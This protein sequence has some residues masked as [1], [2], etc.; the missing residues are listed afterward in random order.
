Q[1]LNKRIFGALI[2]DI[3]PAELP[4]EL[5]STWQLVELAGGTDHEILRAVH[6]FTGEERHASF[7][8]GGLTRLRA[9]LLKAGLD[10][11][12]FEW[13][14]A[15]D[16]DRPPYRGMKP[17]EAEDAGIFFGREAPTID[18]L[19]Q[20]R[21]LR[22]G[23]PPKLLVILGASG[24]GKSSFMRAGVLPRLARDDRNFL[25]LPVLRPGS[26]ALWGDAGLM[27]VLADAFSKAGMKVTQ[28]A[29]RE[30]LAKALKDP[31]SVDVLG[32]WFD[33][34][35]ALG[36]SAALPGEAPVTPSLVLPID[37]GEEL[38]ASEGRD[39]A[40]ACLK[41][42]RLFAERS[43]SPL[44]V[45]FT[46]RSDSY[47]YLQTSRALEGLPQH[48]F[49]LM[50]MPAGAYHSIIEGPAA[51]LASS[52]RP[53]SIDPALTETL[54]RDIDQGG[55]KDA[56]PLLAFTLE[57]L[58]L[59]YGGDGDLTL[60]EYKA[61]GGVEG[62]ISAA[63]EVVFEMARSDPKLPDD[64]GA[65]ELLVRRALVP[66]LA[67][68]DPDTHAPRRRVARLR[69]IPAEAQPVIRHLVQQRL[70]STDVNQDG[71]TTVEPTH[72]ALLRQWG[73][74]KGWLEE[75]FAALSVLDALQRAS[76]DW[77]ANDRDDD[78]LNHSAGRLEDAERLNARDDLASFLG[79]DDRAYLAACREAENERR[80]R[81]LREAQRLAKAR[82]KEAAAQKRVAARTR[83]GL[84]VA[85]ALTVVAVVLGLQALSQQEKA[86]A[87]QA[88]LLL[89]ASIETAAT[90]QAGQSVASLLE[91]LEL[92]PGNRAAMGRLVSLLTQ[93]AF[94]VHKATFDLFDGEVRR[95]FK[96]PDGALLVVLSAQDEA[97]IFD[98]ANGTAWAALGGP[99]HVAN[100]A[101]SADD[102]WL[103]LVTT[104]GEIQV[105][106]RESGALEHRIEDGPWPA[107]LALSAD[108]S[109]VA[110][111]HVW[112][113]GGDEP[114]VRSV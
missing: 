30:A 42:I 78:W 49:S 1:R 87:S 40:E 39:E 53:L 110:G 68:I 88:E 13:P 47:D 80:E 34:L 29:V 23:P 58:Y 31:A 5:T 10:P 48:T 2:D 98:V 24:A 103:A 79:T 43:E 32:G 108:G 101:F 112:D 21:G 75:D 20:L 26:A 114:A 41:L 59:E 7:S 63:A 65:L 17:L 33:E 105:W 27:R 90:G 85:S 83:A 38:F 54:M 73:L 67:G 94:P 50:P 57:R 72:E 61:M 89:N 77:L 91:A 6:P 55:S 35:V 66:W 86:V 107:G 18:L 74:L 111:Q 71:E 12:F 3:S 76:R 104:A 113:L 82:E 106:D 96:S 62:A 70:L 14:P 4:D 99:A 44:I 9:G 92:E 95:V 109:Y 93:R 22:D 28:G 25:P 84:A 8:R 56:L 60:D 46:I 97:A 45:M 16:P 36:T 37:Q 102:R 81:A 15:D 69:E 100:V 11:K 64:R 51:R 52:D 19:A